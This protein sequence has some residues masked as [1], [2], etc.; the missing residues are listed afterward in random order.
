MVQVE[1]MAVG[2]VDQPLPHRQHGVIRQHREGE[3]HLVHLGI[4]VAAHTQQ[5]GRKAV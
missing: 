1:H 3:Y 5:L 4:A 2:D